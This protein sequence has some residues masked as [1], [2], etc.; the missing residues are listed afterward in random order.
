MGPYPPSGTHT[1]SVFVFALK[2]EP[3][4]VKMSFDAGGNSIDMIYSS[5]DKDK[6]GN[7]GNVIAFS[8]LDGNYT[9]KD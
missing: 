7:T 3:G 5:L 8:R 1:Y 9:H 2:D 4:K 6:D